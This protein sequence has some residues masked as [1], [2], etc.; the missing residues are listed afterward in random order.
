MR[1]WPNNPTGPDDYPMNPI[2]L[3]K[4]FI[5]KPQPPGVKVTNITYWLT[6]LNVTIESQKFY[7]YINLNLI[8][9]FLYKYF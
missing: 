7:V 1:L 4:N 6:S 8:S 9:L 2:S 5:I 3:E